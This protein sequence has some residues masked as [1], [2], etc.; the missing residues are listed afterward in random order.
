MAAGAGIRGASGAG[1]DTEEC[2][3]IAVALE[4][5]STAEKLS[6]MM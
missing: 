1:A 5:A 6:K 4:A 3:W 2:E